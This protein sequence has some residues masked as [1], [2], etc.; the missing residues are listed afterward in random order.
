MIK[1]LRR[2]AQLAQAAYADLVDGLTSGQEENLQAQALFAST[3]ATEL[4]QTYSRVVAKFGDA[5]G[6]SATV[7]SDGPGNLVLAIRGTDG[8][9]DIPT[10]GDIFA[11]GAAY[12]QIVAM[13]N[14]WN[15]ASAATSEL[16]TQYRLAWHVGETAPEGT[17]LLKQDG[18][19]V[20]ILEE[21]SQDLRKEGRTLESLKLAGVSKAEMKVLLR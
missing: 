21:A 8:L 19:S 1:Q 20:L 12:E 9:E 2:L 5:T 7:F 17:V 13:V 4:T 6:F 11:A 10:D 14:W 15:R 16:V 18:T 3:Q